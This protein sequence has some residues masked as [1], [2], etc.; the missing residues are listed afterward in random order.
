MRRAVSVI[1]KRSGNH[2]KKIREFEIDQRGMTVGPPLEGFQ[3]VL[4]GVPNFVGAAAKLMGE[5]ES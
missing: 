1:K 3:G 5:P 2:E 4:R